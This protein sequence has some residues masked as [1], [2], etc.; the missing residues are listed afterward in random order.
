MLVGLPGIFLYLRLLLF[1]SKCMTAFKRYHISKC[2]FVC[3]TCLQFFA[4]K[5]IQMTH[6]WIFEFFLSDASFS[7]GFD[8]HVTLS[9]NRCWIAGNHT[10]TDSLWKRAVGKMS[11]KRLPS[12]LTFNKK[13]LV[14]WNQERFAGM[15][16][17]SWSFI[18]LS[19]KETS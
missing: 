8:S 15:P 9:P 1:W 5:P 11:V 19:R 3:L 18:T 13:K 12:D 2:F 14:D 4:L 10:A 7:M 16:Q 6:F 17:F